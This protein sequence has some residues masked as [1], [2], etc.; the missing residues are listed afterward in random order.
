MRL[1]FLPREEKFFFLLHQSAMNIQK[2]AIKLQDL[3]EDYTNV[4]A[5]VEEIKVLEEF[6]DEA[7]HQIMQALHRTFVTP[8]DRE[9]IAHLA[10]RL[11]DVVD[12][13]EEA[14]RTML[15]YQVE[16]P[17]EYAIEM[18]RVITQCGEHLE[19]AVSLLSSRGSKL[20]E[21]LPHTVELNRLENQ[22]DQINS[23]A[24]GALFTNSGNDA[25]SILK[26]R[27]IY[28]YLENATDRAEDAANVL[29]AIVLKHA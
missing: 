24:M 18:S 9:D 28:A 22:G 26:W 17:T 27:D 15:E 14:A 13:I 12:A 16:A 1:A 4:P 29:E 10:E 11:D 8:L 25:I 6:G 19:K 23:R 5:K 21:I 7:I 2:V 20:K 3:M